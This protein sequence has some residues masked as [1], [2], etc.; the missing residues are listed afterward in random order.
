V[1]GLA[2][3]GGAREAVAVDVPVE[4]LQFV[5]GGGN[6]DAFTADVFRRANRGNQLAKGRA[7][8]LRGF[9]GALL[10]EARSAFPEDTAAYLA[11]GA[12]APPPPQPAQPAAPAAP[13]PPAA[14]APPPPR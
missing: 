1:A 11:L 7:A 8:A 5:D 3:L 6:P 12:P 4:L 2:E 10:A 13:P 9:R 14:Q